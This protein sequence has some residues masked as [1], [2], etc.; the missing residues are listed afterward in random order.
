MI[1]H[2][3]AVVVVISSL[4]SCTETVNTIL[5]VL[6]AVSCKQINHFIN[7]KN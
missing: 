4:V 5:W 3:I 1:C 2:M 7:K 6:V